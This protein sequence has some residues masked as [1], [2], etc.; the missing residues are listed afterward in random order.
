MHLHFPCPVFH[1]FSTKVSDEELLFLILK[2]GSLAPLRAG[3]GAALYYY[4]YYA[5]ARAMVIHCI[6]ENYFS[7]WNRAFLPKVRC[8][9]SKGTLSSSK[10]TLPFSSWFSS[11]GTL[12]FLPENSSIKSSVH[13]LYMQKT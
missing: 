11:K 13:L 4:N 8:H 7:H 2:R 3:R 6:I 10:G 5:R 12:L 1:R 9:S